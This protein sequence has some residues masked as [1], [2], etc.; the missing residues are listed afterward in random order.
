VG[1][2]IVGAVDGGSDGRET[3]HGVGQGV[4]LDV[5]AGDPGRD[6]LTAAAMWSAVR[7]ISALRSGRCA[8]V[9]G[10]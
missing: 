9:F 7:A 8:S 10:I 1:L 4:V 3:S 6:V 5:V 2:Q